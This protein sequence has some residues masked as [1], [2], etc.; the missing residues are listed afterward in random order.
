MR[1]HRQ[2]LHLR[3]VRQFRLGARG[4]LGVENARAIDGVRHAIGDELKEEN[5]LFVE[6]ARVHGAGMDDTD[7][8]ARGAQWRADDRR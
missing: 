5:V 8:P 7:Q 2:E 6:F 3:A 1:H 4:A